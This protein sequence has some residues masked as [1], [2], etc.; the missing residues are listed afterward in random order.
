MSEEERNVVMR[1]EFR[2]QTKE[3][4]V[5]YWI[6]KAELIFNGLTQEEAR[7]KMY[8]DLII[9][10]NLQNAKKMREF[11]DKYDPLK[12]NDPTPPSPTQPPSP[13]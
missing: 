1:L 3:L 6:R 9:K 12:T 4:Q 13:I 8:Q 11:Q 5:L 2:S 7:E 10:G